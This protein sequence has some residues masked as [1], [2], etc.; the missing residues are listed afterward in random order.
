MLR[1]DIGW[2]DM[3]TNSSGSLNTRL[4]TEIVTIKVYH[5]Q[6][7]NDCPILFV[8]LS[9]PNILVNMHIVWLLCG[10]HVEN[11]GRSSWASCSKQRDGRILR[12]SGICGR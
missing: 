3:P 5:E 4:A 2:F 10:A 7:Y 6:F 11:Y 12:C 8:I 1:Q 9:S